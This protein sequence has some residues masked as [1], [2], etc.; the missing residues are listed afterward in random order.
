MAMGWLTSWLPQSPDR[1]WYIEVGLAICAALSGFL[2][3]RVSEYRAD[4]IGRQAEAARQQVIA[5]LATTRSELDQARRKAEEF[6][7]QQAPR[8][9]TAEQRERLIRALSGQKSARVTVACPV[10]DGEALRFARDVVD[11]LKAAGWD[12]ADPQQLLFMPGNPIGFGVVVKDSA[13]PPIGAELLLRTLSEAGLSVGP[14]VKSEMNPEI[15]ML[16]VGNKP[17]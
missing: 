2:L 15:I 6:E 8:R 4:V 5:D 11:V 1:L 3:W 13:H 7:R 14:G 16:V 10:G 9:I 12:V 17:R